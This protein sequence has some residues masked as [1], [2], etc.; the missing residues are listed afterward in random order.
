MPSRTPMV[1]IR[2]NATFLPLRPYWEKM[3]TSFIN[4]AESLTMYGCALWCRQIVYICP[5]S[6]NTTTAFYSVTECS[7]VTVFLR[8]CACIP[9]HIRTLPG[10]D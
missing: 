1:V 6:L 5:Y 10:L 2:F 8:T 4:N 9:Q 3:R 7:D